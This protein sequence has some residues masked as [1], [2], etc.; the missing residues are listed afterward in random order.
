MFLA[1]RIT[2][3]FYSALPE[4]QQTSRQGRTGLPVAVARKPLPNSG[5]LTVYQRNI[6]RKTQRLMSDRAM[7]PPCTT[8]VGGLRR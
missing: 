2:I 1:K 8:G 5:A 7:Q 6:L 4:L 3:F